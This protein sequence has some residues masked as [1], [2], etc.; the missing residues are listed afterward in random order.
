MQGLGCFVAWIERAQ[1]SKDFYFYFL[2]RG[3]SSKISVY[4]LSSSGRYDHFAKKLN[5]NGFKV[6]AMDWIGNCFLQGFF[7]LSIHF[8][9]CF[10]YSMAQVKTTLCIYVCMYVCIY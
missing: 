5:D 7:M 6:Y 3:T 2:L 9:S 10:S 4:Y 8:S 1:V